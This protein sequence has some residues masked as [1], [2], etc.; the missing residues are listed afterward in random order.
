MTD[1]IIRPLQQKPQLAVNPA[2]LMEKC[3]LATLSYSI[4]PSGGPQ[5]CSSIKGYVATST[6]EQFLSGLL[7]L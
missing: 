3:H 2:L 6:G 7:N 5:N 1:E 4:F